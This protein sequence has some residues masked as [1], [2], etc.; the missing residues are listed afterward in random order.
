MARRKRGSSPYTPY[1]QARTLLAELQVQLAKL[2][3]SRP[4]TPGK[5][6]AKTRAINKLRRRIRAT[7]GKL[8][9]ARKKIAEAARTR[10]GT[11]DAARIKRSAAAKKG[12]ATRL[13]RLAAIATDASKFMPMLTRD[14]VIWINPL[15]G[16][17]SLLGTYWTIVGDRVNNI[18]TLLSL[19]AFDGLS[20]VDSETG[21]S[22]PF[23]TDM[24]TILAH[25]DHFDFGP[26]FYKS[27]GDVPRPAA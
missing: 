25:H 3:G 9:K 18:P 16:D 11:S 27:R 26:S 14:G 20:I 19:D 8:T 15:G 21:Q 1:R 5:K 7:R 4:R 12:W 13:A 10:A 17:R 24:D 23:I 22:Y 2:V 6:G